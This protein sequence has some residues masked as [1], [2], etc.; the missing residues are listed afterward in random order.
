LTTH[1]AYINENLNANPDIQTFALPGVDP[2]AF[3]LYIQIL[4]TNR[5]PSKPPSATTNRSEYTPL[6]KLYT[7][8]TALRDI[9]TKNIAILAKAKENF[10]IPTSEHVSIIYLATSGACAARK[11]MVDFYT[12]KATERMLQGAFPPEFMSDLAMSLV[13]KREVPTMGWG[14][15]GMREEHRDE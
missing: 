14:E 4:Y 12:F 9:T 2:S 8:A 6:C 11:M 10:D 1:S 3:A 7:L 5:L 15:S 13:S